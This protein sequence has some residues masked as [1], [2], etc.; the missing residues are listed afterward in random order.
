MP[1]EFTRTTI[2]DYLNLFSRQGADATPGPRLSRDVQ[3]VQVT[4]DL[5]HLSPQLPNVATS[6]APTL[7][8]PGVGL[9]NGIGVTA[10]PGVVVA[11][12]EIANQESTNDSILV[13]GTGLT[14]VVVV[15]L[16]VMTW[17]GTA[18]VTVNAVTMAVAPTLHPNDYI[19]AAGT[20][21][22]AQV[23]TLNPGQSLF[24]MSG[25]ANATFTSAMH[26]V[27]LPA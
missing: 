18:Q 5:S 3:L 1:V 6:L 10:P 24:H 11:F 21:F 27:E 13:V 26:L 25:T 2:R 17:G 16:G 9:F 12:Q 22:D 19:L 8:A 4:D 20:A 23:I 7:A 15:A 14:H